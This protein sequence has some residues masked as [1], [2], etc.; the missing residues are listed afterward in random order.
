MHKETAPCFNHDFGPS[1]V[2][3]TFSTWT[4]GGL[5]PVSWWL[6][7]HDRESCATISPR[8]D[9][10]PIAFALRRQLG[11]WSHWRS[12]LMFRCC[13]ELKNKRWGC[14]GTAVLFLNGVEVWRN[15]GFRIHVYLTI[16]SRCWWM[17][18]T[19]CTDRLE[20][21]MSCKGIPHCGC[22]TRCAKTSQTIC[23]FDSEV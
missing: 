17:T 8:S 18:S 19:T 16:C 21:Q 11:L 10:V 23:N 4:G 6:S 12:D 7:A 2:T 22:N 14:E 3:N 20:L 1:K 15:P 5:Q 9:K 13:Q